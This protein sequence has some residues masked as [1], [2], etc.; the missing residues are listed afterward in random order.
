MNSK[1]GHKGEEVSNM[2]EQLDK[3][4]R[5]ATALLEAQPRGNTNTQTTTI[6]AGSKALW[7][8]LWL[9][10]TCCIVMF[11]M[12]LE[13]RDKIDN[14]Q[15]QLTDVSRKLDVAQD[16]LSIV[17]QWAPNLRDEVNKEM[18]EKDKK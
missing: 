2:D 17:L 6:D 3:F 18:K 8:G 15:V 7:F 1:E 12:G 16:K 10:T 14:M 11:I 4:E 13:Q 9:A 5:L